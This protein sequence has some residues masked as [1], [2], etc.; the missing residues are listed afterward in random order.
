MSAEIQS[1]TDEAIALVEGAGGIFEIR[2][3]G[4]LLWKKRQSGVFPAKGEA[5]ALFN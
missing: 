1:V 4:E 5:S 2:R 3:N